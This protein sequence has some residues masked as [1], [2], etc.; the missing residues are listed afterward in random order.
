MESRLSKKHALKLLAN[1][2]TE[3]RTIGIVLGVRLPGASVFITYAK[4]VMQAKLRYP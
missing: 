1:E 2:S 3:G 4:C